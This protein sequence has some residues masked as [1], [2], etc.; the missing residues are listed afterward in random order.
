MDTSI[1][2]RNGVPTFASTS[3]G[4]AAD[5]DTIFD[6]DWARHAFLISD[7][8]LGDNTDIANR[9]WSSASAKFTDSRLGCNIGI[10]ARPQFT[11]YSDIREKGRLLSRNPVSLT[12][13]TGNHGMGRA[14]SENIDDPAQTIYMRFGHPQFNS[15]T[16]FLSRA[17]DPNQSS[18]ARTGKGTSFFYSL[19]NVVGTVAMVG[20]FPGLALTVLAG[21]VISSVFL[22]PTSKFYTLK[23]AMHI[24]WSTVNTLV[25]SLAINRG[26]F[27]KIL[28]TDEEQRLG[29]PYKLDQKTL[30]NLSGLMPDV[31]SGSSYFDM[32]NIANKA[33][34]IA[35]NLFITDY[36]SEDN[37]TSSNYVGYLKK[38][39]AGDTPHPTYISDIKGEK[40][41]GA[42]LNRVVSFKHWFTENDKDE[43][44]VQDPRI[45]PTSDPSE[46]GG[47]QQK[48]PGFFKDIVDALDAEFRDGSQYA[49]FKVDHTGSVSESFSNSTVESTLSSK[50]NSASSE[51]REARFNFAEGNIAGETVQAVIGAAKDVAAGALSGATFGFSDAIL[52]LAGS[53]YIDIPK[54]W[55]SSTAS[56]PRSSYTMQLISPYGNPMSQIMNIDIPLAMILAASLPLSTGKQSYTSPFLCEIYDRGRSQIRLGMIESLSITRGTSNLAFNLKGNAMAVDVT[57][58]VTDLSS[59]MHMPVSP[60]KLFEADMT[61]DEDNILSDYLAV[62][63][64]QDLYTQA[65]AF[66]KAKLA[67]AK[68]IQATKKLTSPGYWASMFHESSTSG[69]LKYLTLGTMNVVEGLVAGSGSSLGSIR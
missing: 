50:L 51:V 7:M 14:Y 44:M 26:I 33:Q 32:Y 25:N 21:K 15:L 37:A 68:R 17:F 66:P 20:A 53:G 29:R 35:N 39:G 10:N 34:R 24:Y 3:S 8:D 47:G 60:G 54:H 30:D 49:I 23:P 58:T 5:I 61:L 36:D 41:L 65:Y 46:K 48:D 63:A 67:L 45:D 22:R 55:Q 11:R 57:F 62:L 28:N 6:S 56:L 31:F 38:N 43:A 13:I 18:I 40:K 27:P 1:V 19:G 12:N 4:L 2:E 69:S 59:I 64:G 16:T 52:G 9:Y 42:Y